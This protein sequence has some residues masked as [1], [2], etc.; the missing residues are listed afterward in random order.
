[1]NVL[2]SILAIMEKPNYITTSE[3]RECIWPAISK[4]CKAK[5]LPAQSLFL[6]LKNTE[7]FMKYVGPAE[8]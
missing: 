4:L 3:F 8:F 2:P 7:L 1:V 6:I 5:E